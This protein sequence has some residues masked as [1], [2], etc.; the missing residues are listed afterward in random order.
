MTDI[1]NRIFFSFPEVYQ[2]ANPFKLLPFIREVKDLWS[3]SGS[4]IRQAT[5]MKIKTTQHVTQL[6]ETI[7]R[8]K[9]RLFTTPATIFFKCTGIVQPMDLF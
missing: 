8:H 9:V 2:V 1:I 3:S 4:S 7:L 6:R 5:K